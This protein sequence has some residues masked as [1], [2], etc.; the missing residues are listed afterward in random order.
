MDVT[1]RSKTDAAETRKRALIHYARQE[2]FAHGIHHASLNEVVRR[3]GGSKATVVKYFG[4]RNGLFAAAL[5]EN[6]HEGMT[7]LRLD[8]GGEARSLTEQVKNICRVLLNFYLSP[9]ALATYRGIIATSGSRES[10][11]SLFYNHGHM[12]I[13][14]EVARSLECWR[15][16][17]IG[18]TLDLEAEA[19][20]LTHLVRSDLYERALLGLQPLPV[21][22]ADIEQVADAAAL[23]FLHG[24]SRWV[25]L[26]PG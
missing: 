25:D 19:G 10:Q 22:L 6:A 23:L 3:A 16:R 24:V 14:S 13:V 26:P 15:G 1:S 21:P 5:A 17:G 20:R 8:E 12:V 4:S 11:A 18:Q 7:A 9:H 2:M